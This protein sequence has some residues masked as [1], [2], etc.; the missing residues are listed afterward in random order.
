MS[1]AASYVQAFPHYRVRQ[2]AQAS[3]PRYVVAKRLNSVRLNW[4]MLGTLSG[5]ALCFAF[6][7]L[8]SA[9]LS[10]DAQHYRTATLV[11]PDVTIETVQ[12][13]AP[14]DDVQADSDSSVMRLAQATKDRISSFILSD[15]GQS[16]ADETAIAAEEIP[17]EPAEITYPYTITHTLKKGETLANILTDQSIS[18]QHAHNAIQSLRSSFNPRSLRE[19]QELTLTVDQNS[20]GE[21]VL[22][23]LQI[24]KN[25]IE[26]V[27][28]ERSDDG[29]FST[30][31]AQKPLEPKLTLAGGTIVSSLFET[32]YASGIPDGVLAELMK[33]YSYD[34]DFQREIQRGDQIE[35]LFEK[36]VT[37]EGE[38]AGYGDILYATLKLRG[39]PLSIYRYETKDGRTGFY[40]EKGESVVKALL[41]TPI[42][43]ARMSS[44]FGQRKHPILGY[45]KMHTGTDFAAPTGTPIYAAGEGVVEFA[46]RKGG[47][48]NYVQI[49]HNGTYATAYAHM[50]RF[51]SGMRPGKPVKQ[52]QVIGYVGSTGRSTGPHL[53]YEVI[54][55]GRKVNPMGEKFQTG[56]R[57]QGTELANFKANISKLKQQV[58]SMPREQT[59]V[60]SAQ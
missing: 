20:E 46:G 4:F 10:D 23:E 3:Q 50:H 9:F 30:E 51:A 16:A 39:K 59:T 55:N 14:M 38:A 52:G 43:G 37:D 8:T 12:D 27:V 36:M 29:K 40:N 19:G 22:S 31:K 49:K 33:A 17:Q 44:G 57:L 48:G 42:N 41:K 47:Y 18:Y 60:A 54:K 1:H 34:V 6:N 32:G 26:S 56:N 5:M 24:K 2:T 58:A 25:T 21:I 53:H 28:L 7:A 11:A 35:V 45:N 13:E 15:D